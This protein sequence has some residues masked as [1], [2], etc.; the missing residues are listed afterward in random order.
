MKS[1]LKQ[2]LG[3][4]LMVVALTALMAF[5]HP[6]APPWY[7]VVENPTLGETQEVT[8]EEVL[9]G[10]WPDREI[11]WIDAR[12][13]SDYE[14]GH[15]EGALLLNDA[16]FEDQLW[17]HSEEFTDLNRLIVVYCDGRECQRSTKIAELL[18]SRLQLRE[19]WVLRGDWQLLSE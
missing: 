3:I 8:V 12:A 18:R 17:E 11:L 10:K 16:E 1:F 19:V 13:T 14:A 5:I 2:S 6:Q 9:A 7:R 15:L 4:I